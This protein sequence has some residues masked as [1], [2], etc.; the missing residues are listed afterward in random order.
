MKI[1]IEW[2]K[3]YVEVTE[4]PQKLKDDLSTIGLLV[5]SA[6]ETQGTT[7]LDIEVTSNRPDCLSYIGIAREVAA[8]YNR[9]L[10][11]PPVKNNLSLE[12]DT[13]PYRI[14]IRDEALCPRY[15]ALV[16]DGVRVGPSPEWMR[17]R[18][19]AAGM[20]P[21]NNI[22]DITN[23]VL[24]ERGHPLH[25]FDFDVLRGG[26]IVVARAVQGARM[27]TL[28]GIDRELDGEML[29]I[30]DGGGPVAIAGV[31]GGLNSEIS[32][33]TSRVLL[34]SAYFEP[35]S[36]RRT[37]RKLGLS[38]EASYRFERGCDWENTVGAMARTC[39]LIEELAGG[40]IAGGI[41][42]VYPVKKD[43]A[44]I[45][46]HRGN[47]NRLL[48]VD[49]S[50]EFIEATLARLCFKMEK[51]GNDHWDVI[52]PTFRADMEIEEDLI[53]ELARFFGYQNIPA[54]V[55][56]CSTIG[57]FS[58]LFEL[59]N[60]VR[61][62]MT[63]QGYY[64]AV[65]LSFAAASDHNEFPPVDGDRAAVRNPLTEDTEFMRSAMVPGLLRSAK[66]NIN[67]GR[68]MVRLFEIG[69]VY[70]LSSDGLPA[71]RNAL[72]IL[73]T[74]GHADRNWLQPD[75]AYTYFHI[76]GLAEALMERLR[77]RDYEIR[78]TD[79]I[80]W[81]N[82]ADA[83][84]IHIG[85]ETVGMAGSLAM[86]LEEKYKLKQPVFIAQLDLERIAGYAFGNI[87]FEPLPRF[88]SAE[89]DLSI[90]VDRGLPFGSISREIAGL[91][92][93]ELSEMQLVDVYEGENIP[94]GKSSL[95]LR[96]VFLDRER[97]LTID[98]VQGFIDT[99]LESLNKKYGVELRSK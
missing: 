29:M 87:S 69:K 21:L 9:P 59:E 89:R 54:T 43:P 50:A 90:L 20:R 86:Q 36:I 55:P 53:E 12:R 5:E 82:P 13:I 7:V 44:C 47:V 70:G 64:E 74:G 83:S 71:E 30:N 94:D 95:T 91:G 58:S 81:L 38:T 39:A 60:T 73:A 19:E 75:P 24:L 26:E 35:A 49:L 25:A 92:I 51:C 10:T 79:D 61:E 32:S 4:S 18:L 66:R 31:M 80:V 93:K 97:T 78:R 96:L 84:T 85:S 14:E 1:S 11:V 15:V 62:F 63:A 67:Y 17:R 98:L 40:S 99:V 23:Y 34:E 76:K 33:S 65:N 22:V 45:T 16:M 27:T 6:S 48:G 72:G 77:I 68:Q 28:D 88:P 3:E 56:P 57:F 42:D 52:C 8:L 41:K 37:S 46:L 2:L